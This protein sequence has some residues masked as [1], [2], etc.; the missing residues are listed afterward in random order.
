[1]SWISLICFGICVGIIL[2]V[3]RRGA[4][5]FSPARIFGFVWSLAIGLADLKLSALQHNWSPDS[6][7]LLLTA[8]S[9]FLIGTFIVYVLCMRK[10]LVPISMMRES[11]KD[12]QVHEGRL[13]WLICASV[14]VYTVAYSLNFLTRGWVPLFAV[15]RNISRVEFNVSGLTLFLYSAIFIVFFTVMYFLLI[16]GKSKRKRKTILAFAIIAVI[17]SFLLLIIRYPIIMTT[18]ICFIFLYYATHHMRPRIVLPLLAIVTGFFYWISSLRFSHVVSTY[19]Y[20]VSKMRFPK[21]F[22]FLTE[23]YMYVVMNLENFAHSISQSDYHTYGY[24]TF[25]FITAIA[26]LK[27]WIVEYF[28]LERMPYLTSNYNTYTALWWF[29]SDFGVVGLAAIP[30]LLGFSAGILY[31]RMR[32]KPTMQS[33]TAYAVTVF[34][35]FISYFNFPISFLWFNYNL[36]AMYLFMRWTI[37]PQKGHLESTNSRPVMRNA[38]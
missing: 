19:L 18:M 17:G 11:L 35:I 8:V 36:L 34:V 21:D 5:P 14:F 3:F 16:R 33:V 22:A 9:A 25:D 15:G 31:Y 6:W 28:N 20:S 1:M 13:F 12:V 24:F 7:V 32:T 10:E 27:Y 37:K 2:S 4:D 23:P 30:L 29:Y 38:W 26:G